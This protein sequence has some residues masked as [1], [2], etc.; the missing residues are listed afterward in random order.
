MSHLFHVKHANTVMLILTE[1]A[2]A[3]I[4]LQSPKTNKKG[5]VNS[6]PVIYRCF[7]S[8]NVPIWFKI[9]QQRLN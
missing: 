7:L 8:Q 5:Q 6:L 3:N 9:D 4:P 1:P 2:T